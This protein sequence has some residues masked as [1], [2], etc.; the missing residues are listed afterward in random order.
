MNW[1]RLWCRLGWHHLI[2][3]GE[4]SLGTGAAVGCSRPGCR[5]RD[6]LKP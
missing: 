2:A 1:G 4:P 5:Y 3:I 6:I